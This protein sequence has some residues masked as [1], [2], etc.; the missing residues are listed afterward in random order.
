MRHIVPMH[1]RDSFFEKCPNRCVSRAPENEA[2]RQ[3]GTC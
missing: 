2:V 1:T 3:Y